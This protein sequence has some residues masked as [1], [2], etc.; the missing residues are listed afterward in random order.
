M[1][2]GETLACLEQSGLQ[3]KVHDI[4]Y[5]VRDC[6]LGWKVTPRTR[7]YSQPFDFACPARLNPCSVGNKRLPPSYRGLAAGIAGI[8]GR[9]LYTLGICCQESC[10]IKDQDD[11]RPWMIGF[12]HTVESVGIEPEEDSAI[13][14]RIPLRRCYSSQAALQGRGRHRLLVSRDRSICKGG[15]VRAILPLNA[16]AFRPRDSCQ[17]KQRAGT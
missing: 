9:K 1:I 16:L 17:V 6:E 8:Y 10:G 2:S 12:Q 3:Y 15:Q 11:L 5:C 7:G 13:E 4:R 14:E